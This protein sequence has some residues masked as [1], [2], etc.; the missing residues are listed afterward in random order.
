MTAVL[1]DGMPAAVLCQET[2]GRAGLV[3]VGFR[4]LTRP[5]EVFSTGSVVVPVG[6]RAGLSG[7]GRPGG[8]TRRTAS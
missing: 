8:G 3:V 2:E 1:F 5:E 6:A 4:G 7:G